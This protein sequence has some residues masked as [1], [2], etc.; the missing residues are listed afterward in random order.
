MGN[1]GEVLR[2]SDGSLWQVQYEYL[3][4]YEYSAEAIVCPGQA[5]LI[6]AGKRIPA[7][8]LHSG[9]IPRAGTIIESRIEG[10]FTGWEGETIFKLDNGQ[11]WQ[12]AQYAYRYHYAYR[13]RVTIVMVDGAYEMMVEGV[14]D[15]IRVRQLR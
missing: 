15:R 1:H 10:E 11:I 13:P 12:Q 2:L 8:A 9:G 6:I 4:L 3:Y 7:A 5:L 14:T